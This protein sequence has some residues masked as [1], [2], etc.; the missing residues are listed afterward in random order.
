MDVLEKVNFWEL[1]TSEVVRVTTE[2]STYHFVRRSDVPESMDMAVISREGVAG[3][4][5]GGSF[6][7][8]P[9]AMN[10]WF[11][12]LGRK[13]SYW[14]GG[15]RLTTSPVKELAVLSDASLAK[16]FTALVA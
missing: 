3:C 4:I 5:F 6:V 7:K 2:D 12:E 11:F 15:K 9:T 14:V 10:G 8:E 16:R 13:I 1:G